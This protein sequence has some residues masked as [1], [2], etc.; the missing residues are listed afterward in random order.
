VKNEEKEAFIPWDE[1]CELPTPSKEA[2]DRK[3]EEIEKTEQKEEVEK[4]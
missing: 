1:N 2:V 3:I 4:V